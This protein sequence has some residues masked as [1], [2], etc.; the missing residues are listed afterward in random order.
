MF[1]SFAPKGEAETACWASVTPFNTGEC[2][3]FVQSAAQPAALGRTC[4]EN[5]D[6]DYDL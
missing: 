1:P 3:A 6:N 5:F 2:L 4:K